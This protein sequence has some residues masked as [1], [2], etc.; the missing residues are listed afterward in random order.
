MFPRGSYPKGPG[1]DGSVEVPPGASTKKA[2][3]LIFI[4]CVVMTMNIMIIL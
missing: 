2:L 4:V 1:V 3:H